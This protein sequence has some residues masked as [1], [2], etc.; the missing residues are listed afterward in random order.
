M[1][2][3]RPFVEGEPVLVTMEALRQVCPDYDEQREYARLA[4][5][6]EDAVPQSEQV[7]VLIEG[8]EQPVLVATRAIRRIKGSWLIQS[9]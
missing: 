7:R 4:H 3:Q 1:N 9:E 6:V 8:S 5:L 2:N